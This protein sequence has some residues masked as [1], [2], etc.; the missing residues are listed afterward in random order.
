MVGPKD[1]WVAEAYMET[2][3]SNLTQKDLERVLLDY[4]LFVL[5]G[6]QPEEDAE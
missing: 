2:D 1:E 3:Y 6:S 5:K 4:A